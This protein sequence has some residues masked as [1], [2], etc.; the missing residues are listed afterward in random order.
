M[1]LQEN[2]R[3]S[4]VTFV[5]QT[6]WTPPYVFVFRLFLLFLLI[7]LLLLTYSLLSSTM[8]M[9]EGKEKGRED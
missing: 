9:M 3:R 6:C 2:E 1:V 5:V 4:D 8:I 7:Q